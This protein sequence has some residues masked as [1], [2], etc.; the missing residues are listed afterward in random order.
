MVYAVI[1]AGGGPLDLS[2]VAAAERHRT[3]AVRDPRRHRRR[4]RLTAAD[5]ARVV[6][7]VNFLAITSVVVVGWLGAVGDP[8]A[9]DRRVRARRGRRLLL[10]G[11]QRDPAAHPAAGAAARGER[12][13]GGDPPRA[14]AGGGPRR[15]RHAG[16]RRHG[17]GPRGAR[18]RDRARVRASCCCCSCGPSR[19]ADGAPSIGDARSD[20][21]ACSTTCARRSSSPCG[22]RG[23]CGPCCTR[24]CGCSSSVG[25]EEVLLPVPHPRAHRRG[26]A[27]VRVP[28][29]GLRPRRRAR[30]DRRVVQ[31]AAAALPDRDEPG[32]GRQHAAVHRRGLHRPVLAACWPSC[33]IVRLRLQLRQRHLGHAAAA[34]R[35]H[36]T[37]SG[38]SR[39]STSS[40]RSRSCRCRWRSRGRCREVL[41]HAGDLHSRRRPP[42]RCSASSRSSRRGCR[43]TRSPIR[44]QTERARPSRRRSLGTRPTVVRGAGAGAAGLPR[45]AGVLRRADA[46]ARLGCCWRPGC[47]SRGWCADGRMPQRRGR[48]A[49]RSARPAERP[50]SAPRACCATSR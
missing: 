2:L 17:P 5:R 21:R 9:R 33:F 47:W 16:G 50:A 1:G 27:L 28:P 10:P 3:A 29:R 6:E 40:S 34:A 19:R 11:L 39:A 12:A 13:R 8:A 31:D 38:A 42:A 36:G 20:A 43:R 24:R 4:P 15:R 49:R 44:W 7:L 35:A 41:S 18:D 26:S 37:C 23:C 48:R 46:V 30:L 32:V 14:A 45:R 22:R 25:P